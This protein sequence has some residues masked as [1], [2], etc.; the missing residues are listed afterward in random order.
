MKRFAVSVILITVILLCSSCTIQNEINEKNMNLISYD[1]SDMVKIGA[2]NSTTDK[3]NKTSKEMKGNQ[4]VSYKVYEEKELEFLLNS[5]P[6]KKT[7]LSRE[8]FRQKVKESP[9]LENL[10]VIPFDELIKIVGKP[11][12]EII[13]FAP[14]MNYRPREPR[15]GGREFEWDLKD[16]DKIQWPVI[17]SNDCK[18]DDVTPENILEYGAVIGLAGIPIDA[19][20]GTTFEIH[21]NRHKSN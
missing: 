3:S 10:D 13:T 7:L 19:K 14:E 20:D 17:L 11:Q 6:D 9:Y 4:T 16:G 18:D 8:E 1:F 2:Q 5:N 15:P 21:L 12:R